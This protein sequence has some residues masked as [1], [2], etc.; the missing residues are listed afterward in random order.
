MPKVDR[1]KHIFKTKPHS[2][3]EYTDVARSK[4]Q[5]LEM[6]K[7]TPKEYNAVAHKPKTNSR[8]A[9]AFPYHIYT[10]KRPHK[11]K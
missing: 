9:D 10:L 1:T 5:A 4:K 11:G 7:H 3:F 6:V 8:D 2:G